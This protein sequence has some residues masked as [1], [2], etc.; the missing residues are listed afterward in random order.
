MKKYTKYLLLFSLFCLRLSTQAS[1]ADEIAFVFNKKIKVYKEDSKLINGRAKEGN[2]KGYIG[3][4][5]KKL[6]SV[7]TQ[8]DFFDN[9]VNNSLETLEAKK[10]IN[11]ILSKIR[12]VKKNCG[13]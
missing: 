5:K 3:F 10:K 4:E 8:E 11:F 6:P 13:Y 7:G 9:I 1:E 12:F 2:K